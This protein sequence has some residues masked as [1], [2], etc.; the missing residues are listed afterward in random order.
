MYTNIKLIGLVLCLLASSWVGTAKAET[1]PRDCKIVADIVVLTQIQVVHKGVSPQEAAANAPTWLGIKLTHKQAFVAA[2]YLAAVYGAGVPPITDLL[3]I[4][5]ELGM[6][7]Q[8]ACLQELG[9]WNKYWETHD[10]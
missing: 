3:D 9:D 10:L 5:N 2:Q 1:T 7:V 4:R 6:G 8:S